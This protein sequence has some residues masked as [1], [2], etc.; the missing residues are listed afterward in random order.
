MDLS[1]RRAAAVAA[2]LAK[3]YGVAA[4]RMQAAGVGFQ[5]PVASNASEEGRAQNR[6]VEL[7][8]P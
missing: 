5:A 3:S 4:A 7:V 8:Q 1:R 6:R 2:A